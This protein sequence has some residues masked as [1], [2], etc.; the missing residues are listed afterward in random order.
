M[1]LDCDEIIKNLFLYFNS[2]LIQLPIIFLIN[3]YYFLY[4]RKFIDKY[5]I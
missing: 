4:F 5:I 1:K 3:N 2:A